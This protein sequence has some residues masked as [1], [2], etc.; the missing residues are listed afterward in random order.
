MKRKLYLLPLLLA[1]C[2]TPLLGQDAYMPLNSEEYHLYHRLEAISGRLNPAEGGSY[3]PLGRK[4]GADFF[5]HIKRSTIQFGRYTLSGRDQYQIDRA[6][7]INGEWTEDATGMDGAR[8]SKRPVLR[9]FYTTKENLLHYHGDDFFVAVNP[10]LYLNAGLD[11]TPGSNT[12]QHTFT[13][14][15][16]G[17]IRGRIAN[18]IGF[19]TLLGDNQERPFVNVG[20]WETRYKSFPGNDFYRRLDN[21]TFDAFVGR[22]Y[23][24]VDIVPRHFKLAFG[25]DKQFIGNGIRSLVQSNET[26]AGTFLR[27]QTNIGGFQVDNL[28]QELVS[29]F[30]GLGNDDRL[31]RKYASFHQVSRNIGS[32]LSI[33]LFESTMYG[34]SNDFKLTNLIPVIYVNTLMRA[35][36][37][38]QKTSLGLQFKYL[39]ARSVQL[40]GQAMADRIDFRK[41]AVPTAKSTFA[42][43]LGVR[44]FNAFTLS[45]LDLQA[46][47]NHVSPFMYQSN[48]RT[49]NHTHYNQPL[50]HPMG[51][52][53][54]EVIGKARYQ[55]HARIYIDAIGS[56]FKGITP[57]V[58]FNNGSNIHMTYQE[59]ISD[60]HIDYQKYY[61]GAYLNGNIAYELFTNFFLEAGGT[62]TKGLNS[63]GA[64]AYGGLRWNIS[65]KHYMLYN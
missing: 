30:A 23:F 22:G 53:F 65:R 40:Y 3:L 28:Y 27:L 44:Y 39:P 51:A 9:Y 1:S 15:R 21:G 43:Q 42:A 37:A 41:A 64:I 29:D 49:Q 19:Y 38:Q 18:R 48:E 33:A 34:A 50:A 54:T 7:G 5:N 47:V 4:T 57:A 61:T 12:R 6:I 8:P 17:E 2:C 52:G 55:P 13:N 46:E 16:G 62:Y 32:R 10:V 31:P 11:I 25:Y 14:F 20:N 58:P 56:F 24:T 59:W 26:A 36:E 45:N 63:S 35:L 60:H